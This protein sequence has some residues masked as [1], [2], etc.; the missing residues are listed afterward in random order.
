MG[1]TIWRQWLALYSKKCSLVSAVY[2]LPPFLWTVAQT[3]LRSAV[4]VVSIDSQYAR[5]ADVK[6][7]LGDPTKARDKLGWSPSP[8]LGPCAHE[9]PGCALAAALQ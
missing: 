2:G 1:C 3:A 4:V 7:L 5:L 6:T 9:Q 8:M